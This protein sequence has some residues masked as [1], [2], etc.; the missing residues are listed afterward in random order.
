MPAAIAPPPGPGKTACKRQFDVCVDF[1]A[2][3]TQNASK[4]NEDP[5]EINPKSRKIEKDCKKGQKMEPKGFQNLPKPTKME[6]KLCKRDPKV[7]TRE[8]EGAKS[9]RTKK[10]KHPNNGTI[11]KSIKI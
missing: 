2:N 4:I 1:G 10:G 8:P 9:Q 6:Q 3:V 5:F 11:E 7:S